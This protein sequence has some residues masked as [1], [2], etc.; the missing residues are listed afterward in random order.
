MFYVVLLVANLV[1]V[2]FVIFVVLLFVVF[3][4]HWCCFDVGLVVLLFGC[5]DLFVLF[6]RQKET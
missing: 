6:E 1:L 5:V 3:V 2:V 4:C